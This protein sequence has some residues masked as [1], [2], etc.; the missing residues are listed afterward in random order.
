MLPCLLSLT[1]VLATTP[2]AGAAEFVPGELIVRFK[3]GVSGSE[4]ADA[5]RERGASVERALPVPGAQV[6]DLP[7]GQGVRRAA[8]SFENDPRVLYAEP[9]Y[10][11]R[12]RDIS[13][14]VDD[15]FA[16]QLWGL[17]NEGQ[18]GG[19]LDAD[20]DALE[21]W[22]AQPGSPAVKVAVV[23]SGVDLL[24]P[25]LRPQLENGWDYVEGD[26]FPYDG[27]GHGTH[28][29][30]TVG[31]R[32][33]DAIG[34]TGVSR[35]VRI[36]PIRVLD[37]FGDGFL[38]DVE[39]GFQRAADE[40]ASIVNAS[41]GGEG[42]FPQ[43][44]RDVIAANE[45]VLFVVAAGNGDAQ[46]NPLN[47]DVVPDWPCN[48]V[49]PAG[50]A[51]N[52]I[53][54]AASNTNDA[55]ASFSNYGPQNVDIAAPGVR[56]VS[57]SPQVYTHQ[58]NF[59]AGIGA[60][61]GES[62]A[63]ASAWA[64]S[65][66]AGRD[67]DP[68]IVIA[69]APRYADSSDT[70]LRTSAP[71][72]LQG[73]RSCS[74][75]FDLRLGVDDDGGD[76]FKLEAATDPSGPWTTVFSRAADTTGLDFH[77]FVEPL[78]A[79]F[80]GQLT[81]LR[82]R[83]ETDLL[84]ASAD[85]RQGP[86]FDWLEVACARWRESSGTSM[87]T[88]HVSGAAALVLAQTPTLTTTQLKARLLSTGD[89]SACWTGL[90]TTGA[91]L[92][93]GRALGVANLGAGPTASSCPVTVAQQEALKQDEADPPPAPPPPPP[94]PPVPPT[95]TD[96]GTT[97][98]PVDDDPPAV[99]ASA[100]RRYRGSTLL[101]SGLRARIRCDE[102]CSIRTDVLVGRRTA[103][104]LGIK[105]RRFGSRYVLLGR[106]RTGLSRPGSKMVITRISRGAHRGLR[107]ARSVRLVLRVL[108][109]DERGNDSVARRSLTVRR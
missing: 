94:P 95:G 100:A 93:L 68:G 49:P 86:E 29:A 32:G 88:P 76:V 9:N 5:R 4:R 24:H 62:L 35:D 97:P 39:A 65:A 107:R 56:T 70:V 74:V 25:D 108:A 30:G 23:D 2:S 102:E 14:A 44:L 12:A 104:R 3:P 43:S 50:K 67:G 61:Q 11:V 51:D 20:I 90:T 59:T 60:W 72:D 71:I 55:P 66:A 22:G 17:D 52:V 6:L 40:G 81:Y 98:T 89:A 58:E 8:K 75:L 91:R 103:K 73:E 78:P 77:G 18:F 46:G 80:D 26:A 105:G 1:G 31:A 64:A 54:V 34:V 87:A 83:F 57:T 101:R 45:H 21:G 15:P 82:V 96:S 13:T 53:C 92:N 27:D 106:A 48:Y 33:N 47:N 84:D 28:V 7:A 16:G 42:P 85:A 38:A 19:L 10:V 99:T 36:V 63:G 41:L 109:R 69:P 37:Q 79:A